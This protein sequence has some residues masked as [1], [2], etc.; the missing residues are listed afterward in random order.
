MHIKLD[1]LNINFY[2]L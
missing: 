1:Q 2:S